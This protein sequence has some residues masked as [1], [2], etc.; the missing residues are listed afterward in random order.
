VFEVTE[1]ITV[2]P[3]LA[4]VY[5]LKASG[6][7]IRLPDPDPIPDTIIIIKDQNQGGQTITASAGSIDNNV[8]VSLTNNESLTLIANSGKWNIL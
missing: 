5:I 6:L 2:S 1:D 8:S 7:S 4:E 3:E